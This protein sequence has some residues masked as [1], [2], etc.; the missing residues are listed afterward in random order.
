MSAGPTSISTDKYFQPPLVRRDIES[1]RD[2]A[3]CLAGDRSARDFPLSTPEA[4]AL[5][6]LERTG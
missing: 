5:Y 2:A 1:N 4:P 6:W 3:R